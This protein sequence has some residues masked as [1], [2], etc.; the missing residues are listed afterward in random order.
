M[1]LKLTA[2]KSPGF[3]VRAVATFLRGTDDKEA[4]EELTL[5]ALGNAIGV[6]AAVAAKVE[7]EQLASVTSVQTNYV[8]TGATTSPQL[9][10]KLKA[11][12]PI[13][14]MLELEIKKECVDEFIKVMTA[15]A[16][17]S[18][19]EPGCL[20]FDFIRD[21]ENQCKFMTYEV[22]E[23]DAAMAAHKEM[24]YVKAWG[25]FQYGDKKPVVSKKL[26]V[27]EA[28]SWTQREKGGSS[29]PMVLKVE[30]DIKE[31]CVDEFVKIMS[32][33][34]K[35]SRTEVAC[36]R[37]DLL[38]DKANPCKFFCYEAYSGPEALDVHKEMPYVK[39][40]GAFQYG[41]KKPIADKSLMKADGLD[42]QGA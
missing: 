41:D 11:I 16:V 32:A 22:F 42:Y 36:L 33:S 23:S 40:W 29:A 14:I 24:P 26:S 30:L 28:V 35:G 27:T 19:S 7:K 25:A 10:V 31:E 1:E 5:S 21:K 34:A 8:K 3:Y 37:F 9:L 2:Q 4:V 15:D 39:A 18:R 38:R 12:K 13:A 6:A 17:G 20:R